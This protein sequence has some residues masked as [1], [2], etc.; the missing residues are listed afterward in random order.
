EPRGGKRGLDQSELPHAPRVPQGVRQCHD[1]SV[2]VTDQ[3]DRLARQPLD[4]RLEIA[5]HVTYVVPGW[6]TLTQTVP[7]QVEQDH[8]VVARE[9]GRRGPVPRGHVS[10][11]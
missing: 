9:L 3:G 6:Y 8:P 1:R 4:H 7:A 10:Q 2:T 11:E 5:H